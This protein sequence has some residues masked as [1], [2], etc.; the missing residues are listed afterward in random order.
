MVQVAASVFTLLLCI[1]LAVNHFVGLLVHKWNLECNTCYFYL[2]GQFTLKS[3]KQSTLINST[4]SR[5]RICFWFCVFL[6]IN[7][8]ISTINWCIVRAWFFY[9]LAVCSALLCLS[10][11]RSHF[12]TSKL[13][14]SG[15]IKAKQVFFVDKTSDCVPQEHKHNE[16]MLGQSQHVTV[17]MHRKKLYSFCWK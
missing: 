2:K 5:G 14:K 8:C 3:S 6:Y 7:K 15:I 9:W 10:D 17:K 13:M 12:Q 4:T 1:H 11:K 16:S